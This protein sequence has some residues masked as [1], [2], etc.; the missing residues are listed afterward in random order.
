MFTTEEINEFDRKQCVAALNTLDKKWGFKNTIT[1]YTNEID[2]IVNQVLD[3]EQRIEQH[4]IRDGVEKGMITKYGA[5][6][7]LPGIMTPNGRA[8]SIQAAAELMGYKFNTI[9]SYLTTRPDEYY[10]CE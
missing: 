9:H 7:L 1:Q 3:I 6:A 4:D 5:N 2:A 10:R 8:E